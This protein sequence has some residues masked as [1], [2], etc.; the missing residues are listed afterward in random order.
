MNINMDF[1]NGLTI[2]SFSD[3][4][5]ME[6]DGMMVVKASDRINSQVRKAFG[7]EVLGDY[8]LI[9][10]NEFMI[11]YACEDGAIIEEQR[12]KIYNQLLGLP[13]AELGLDMIKICREAKKLGRNYKEI[14]KETKDDVVDAILSIY[15]DNKDAIRKSSVEAYNG[16]IRKNMNKRVNITNDE[17]LRLF[18]KYYRTGKEVDGAIVYFKKNDNIENDNIDKIARDL[19]KNTRG[20]KEAQEKIN[21]MMV[22]HMKMMD[23]VENCGNTFEGIYKGVGLLKDMAKEVKQME[24]DGIVTKEF[25]E[26][27]RDR[28]KKDLGI[29]I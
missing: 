1:V 23:E 3:F 4:L 25:L 6:G 11:A 12:I 14:L 2:G 18:D 24:A 9:K 26:H 8:V 28:V 27:I 19:H 21:D 17:Q 10:I 22:K 5:T 15:V 7:M 29:D 20:N 13:V 16:M